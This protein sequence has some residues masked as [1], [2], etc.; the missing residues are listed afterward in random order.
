V[1]QQALERAPGLPKLKRF[2]TGSA[3]SV[4][5]ARWNMEVDQRPNMIK[6]HL[7]NE[8]FP[9]NNIDSDQE[10]MVSGDVSFGG[11]TQRLAAAIPAH[12]TPFC[13]R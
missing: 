4:T 5:V 10:E 2:K 7:E 9:Q 12:G 13:A 1:D 6:S 3:V 11:K 8:L